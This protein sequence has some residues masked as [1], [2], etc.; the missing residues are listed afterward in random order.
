MLADLPKD[1]RA[2]QIKRVAS[3][4]ASTPGASLKDIDAACDTGSATKVLSEMRRR[5]YLL[6]REMRPVICDSGTHARLI[7]HY[8]LTEWPAHAKQVDLFEPT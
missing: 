2:A 6:R 4:L 3:F 5:G 7:A 1:S 8:W